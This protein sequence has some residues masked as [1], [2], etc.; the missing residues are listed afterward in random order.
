MRKLRIS[1]PVI[2]LILLT[3]SPLN[4]SVDKNLDRGLVAAERDDYASA[5]K[6]W[7]ILAEKGD[8]HRQATLAVLYHSGQGVKQDYQKA[9]YW[10]KKAAEQGHTSA[11]ANLGV[12]YA[13][14]TGTEQDYIKSYAWYSLAAKANEGRK[15]G[16]D[17]WGL[18]K[19][20]TLL[21][22]KEMQQAKKLSEQLIAKY[23]AKAIKKT[24]K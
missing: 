6:E 18:E 9:F 10:Y 22:N 5:F 17:L 21:S 12:M 13:K 8:P 14:G 19:V 16:N 3:N 7:K 20:G 11:Q 4:A 15:M 24:N 1:S 23:L 2:L